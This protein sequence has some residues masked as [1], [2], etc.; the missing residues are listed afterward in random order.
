MLCIASL[1]SP[2][3]DNVKYYKQSL[4]KGF[5]MALKSIKTVFLISILYG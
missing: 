4:A 1:K 2:F 3:S 5:K